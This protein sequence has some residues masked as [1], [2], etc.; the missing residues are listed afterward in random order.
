[1]KKRSS[2]ILSVIVG[3][4]L[5]AG[6]AVKEYRESCPC[7]LVLDFSEVD[8]SAVRSADLYVT[9]PDGYVFTDYIVLRNLPRIIQLSCRV[10]SCRSI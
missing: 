7:R 8:T 2:G 1:M 4:L 10:P 5:C 9:V 3:V 6:C